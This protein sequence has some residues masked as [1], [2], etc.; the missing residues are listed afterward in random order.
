MVVITAA[1]VAIAVPPVYA[2]GIGFRP[3]QVDTEH[4]FGFIEGADIGDKGER[5]I[6]ADSV[7]LELNRCFSVK[8]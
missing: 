1:I 8:P 4:L 2:D 5:E 7:L 6:V 3:D